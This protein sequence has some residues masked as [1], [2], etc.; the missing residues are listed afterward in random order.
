MDLEQ[1]TYYTNNDFQQ[2]EFYSEGPKGK[3]KK[4]VIFQKAQENPLIYNLAFGDEDPNANKVNDSIASNNNDRDKVLATVA[5]TINDFCDRYGNH[6]I[7][8][9]GSNKVRTRLYQISISRFLEIISRNFDVYGVKDKDA[10]NFE[11]NVNYEGF[12]IKRK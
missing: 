5:N 7:Y 3:I 11:K 1:Y 10:V 8:A 9:E 4:I 12:L 6:Y 2:Y